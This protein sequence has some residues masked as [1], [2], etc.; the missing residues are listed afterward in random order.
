MTKLLHDNH[1]KSEC[2]PIVLAAGS[3][4]T[5]W[6]D[7]KTFNVSSLK[8]LI[9]YSPRLPSKEARETSCAHREGSCMC[10]QSALMRNGSLILCFLGGRMRGL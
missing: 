7:N 2:D 5:H 1:E 6:F 9:D 4:I 10:H 3:D 8:H